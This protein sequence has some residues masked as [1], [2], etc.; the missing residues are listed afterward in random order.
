LDVPWE[1]IG[2][3]RGNYVISAHAILV[4]GEMQT[5]SNARIYGAVFITITGDVDGDRDID[6]FNIV[7]ADSNYKKHW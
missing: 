7:I 6:I 4:E 3:S 5:D 1:T 2:F